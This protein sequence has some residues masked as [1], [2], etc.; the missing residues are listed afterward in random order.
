MLNRI[1]LKMWINKTLPEA[2]FKQKGEKKKTRSSERPCEL[3]LTTSD[4]P[5]PPSSSAPLINASIKRLIYS[6]LLLHCFIFFLS[7]ESRWA[8]PV[9]VSRQKPGLC[10]PSVSVRT[11][12]WDPLKLWL[13]PRTTPPSTPQLLV[14]DFQRWKHG[15]FR[16]WD[17][18]N[19]TLNN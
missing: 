19:V 8:A 16:R 12:T 6:H 5:P 17:V 13:C 3:D 2:E 10:P 14:P 11:I 9:K 15:S 1:K 18:H 4:T 7:A